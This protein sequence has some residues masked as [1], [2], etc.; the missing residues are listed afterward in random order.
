MVLWP[1]KAGSRVIHPR[2]TRDVGDHG[3]KSSCCAPWQTR[4]HQSVVDLQKGP[5]SQNG[6][7]SP[8]YPVPIKIF[9]LGPFPTYKSL[10][11]GSYSPIYQWSYPWSPLQFFI[12]HLP[13][14]CIYGVAEPSAPA[15]GDAI[16][17][18]LF[19]VC[20]INL[21]QFSFI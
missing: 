18:Y 10:G 7:T 3:T 2:C 15:H 19:P 20:H 4:R 5:W 16:I 14:F 9:F 21:I 1:G 12:F 11:C 17:H 6:P 13:S 8:F